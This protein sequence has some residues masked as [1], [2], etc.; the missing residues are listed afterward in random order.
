MER[1]GMNIRKGFLKGILPFIR[2]LPLPTASG[3]LSGFG[4]IEYRLHNSLR[5]AFDNAVGEANQRLRCD[6]DIPSISREL[7][8]NQIL[9]RAG[10]AP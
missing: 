5:K 3:L 4:Q 6:W 2:W 8:G 10:P 1:R 7:A 9:W